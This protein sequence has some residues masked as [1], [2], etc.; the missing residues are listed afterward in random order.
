MVRLVR[1]VLAV[2]CG[3]LAVGCGPTDGQEPIESNRG[4]VEL[5]AEDADRTVELVVGDSLT[6]RLGANPGT[7]FEWEVTTSDDGVVS[8][9]NQTFD[10][11]GDDGEGSPGQQ[12]LV[13]TADGPGSTEL[14]FVYRRPWETEVEPERTVTL[15][16]TVDEADSDTGAGSDTESESGLGTQPTELP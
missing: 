13:L 9:S 10:A 7:G 4:T 5:T 16:L 3:A 11:G 8:L 1:V 12:V 14:T 15:R 2:V 6:M